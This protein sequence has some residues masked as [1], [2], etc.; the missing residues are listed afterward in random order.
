MTRLLMTLLGFMVL[1][2]VTGVTVRAQVSEQ[3][4]LALVALYNATNG[5]N[6]TNNTNWLT[7][8]VSQWVGAV[9]VLAAPERVGYGR[10]RAH[11]LLLLGCS[12]ANWTA[13]ATID[14]FPGDGKR[15]RWA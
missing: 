11:R 5:P 8:P 6:W 12:R 10:T 14:R 7:T 1:V 4:S 3:D 2:T 9:I 15:A 13:N